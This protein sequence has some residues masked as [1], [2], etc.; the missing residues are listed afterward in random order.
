MPGCWLMP[1][2][3]SIVTPTHHV[4]AEVRLSR[5]PLEAVA[6]PWSALRPTVERALPDFL[7]QQRWYPGKDAG[8]PS[9]QLVTLLPLPEDR[10][11]R[12]AAAIWRVTPPGRPSFL[13]FVPLALVAT[14]AADP[15]QVIAPVVE[16]SEGGGT[17]ALVDACSVDE[18][19][20]AW[21]DVHLQAAPAVVPEPLR[22]GNTGQLAHFGADPSG[23]LIKRNTAEQ[24]NT[25]VRIGDRAILKVIR[26][27]EEG[28]HPELEVGRHLTAAGFAAAPALWSWI[29]I[30]GT[31]GGAAGTTL[32]ILQSFVPNE[33]DGWNWTLERL[34]RAAHHEPDALKAAQGWLR[35]VARRTAELH[36][37]FAAPSTEPEFR[38]EPVGAED[39]RGWAEAAHATAERALA[40]LGTGH[41]QGGEDRGNPGAATVGELV[42]E[43]RAQWPAVMEIIHKLKGLRTTFSRTRHHGDFHLGQ[44][45]VSGHDAVI[46][47]F[48]GEPLRP[49]A[50]RR[51]K[52]A[53]LRDVAGML[54]SF[55][56]AAE[57]AARALPVTLGADDRHAALMLFE[58]WRAEV[59]CGFVNEYFAAME[60]ASSIPAKRAEAERLLRFFLLEKALY[61]VSYEMANRPEWVSIPLK[62]VLDL[63]RQ[64]STLSRRAHTMPF[65]AQVR[66]DGSVRFR[67]WA[68]SHSSVSLELDHGAAL[69]PMH[70]LDGGWHELVTD[71]AHVGS[72]YSLVLPDGMRVPDPASRFQPEDVHGPSEVV[73]PTAYRWRNVSWR[74]RPWEEAVVYELHIGTYTSEGSFQAVIDKLDHLAALGVTAIELMPIAGFPGRRSWGYDGVALYAPDA[75]YGRPEELKELIDAAH[76]RGLMVLLDVVYNHFGP[77]GAYI[78]AV[79]PQT[80]TQRHQTPWGAAINTDGEHSGVVREFFIQNAL[81]WIREFQL[82]GLRLD[83]VHAIVDD[84]PK[85][86]LEELAERVRAAEPDRH[87]H[88]VLEN[89][90]NEAPLLTRGSDG[91]PRW[92]S[93]QW[94]DDVHHVLHVA[95][96]RETQ[97]YYVDYQGDTVKLGRAL[98]E[99]FAFQ[100]ELMPYRGRA[101]GQ[102]SN[103]LPPVAF[104]AFI[105]NH[106][107]IGNR[108][109]GERLT[110]LTR[111]DSLRAIVAVYLLLPQIPMLFMGEEWGTRRPFQF[112]CDFEA[113]LAQ[114]VREGRRAEFAR[115]PE[116]H[117]PA[118]RERIPDPAAE[119]TFL[120]SK[121]DWTELAREP[122]SGWYEYYRRL[123][124]LRHQEIVPRLHRIRRGGRFTVWGPGAV[125]VRWSLEESDVAELVIEA[126]LHHAPASGFR[127]KPGRALWREGQV[128]EGGVF[129]PYTV[130]CSLD[131]KPAFRQGD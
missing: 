108:A 68:L 15:T 91:R 5:A 14:E 4:P 58:S 20:Q 66:L 131:D 8:K 38:P 126:N 24:S 65:G 120:A 116:F 62:G 86:L 27:L 90:E 98:A 110:A 61:E 71:Q 39:L 95:A 121:L 56:Y 17:L 1:G 81:Y 78:H 11:V 26:K 69:I 117:D 2:T 47:D 102:P 48:E 33:G 79:A 80:F 55:S 35:T 113:Q 72:R 111:A 73:D 119:E 82:D 112:F 40:S 92:Y 60:G 63:V 49:I 104:V 25:S 22:V 30:A 16:G 77:E 18:F 31:D 100:G 124:E 19:L 122:H 75:S 93:A 43:L 9:V 44:V 64:D 97:G 94:N 118:T 57:A 6:G 109:F 32:S 83:A 127:Q 76:G 105:Q 52:H 23:R 29:E 7:L 130:R 51:A 107:Q 13:L 54:R 37:T 3:P 70:R 21:V 45:L 46:I 123:L 125:I 84:S 115:F 114:A 99:G 128:G 50:E 129:G 67:V 36:R 89:E 10:S 101:R 12:A 96:T 88:L 74:G 34:A 28:P 41:A 85:H 42:A 106:D 59:S 53:V 87:I 103:T